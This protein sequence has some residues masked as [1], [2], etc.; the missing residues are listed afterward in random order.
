MPLVR[1]VCR[2]R[3]RELTRP[4]V[5]Q[6]QG[7]RVLVLRKEGCK[8]DVVRLTVVLDWYLEVGHAIDG[9]LVL[10]PV[11]RVSPGLSDLRAALLKLASHSSST[12][13]LRWQPSHD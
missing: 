10:L 6:E 3:W 7:S 4:A 5:A 13:K 12:E 1:H 8:V 11:I 2:I 9:I